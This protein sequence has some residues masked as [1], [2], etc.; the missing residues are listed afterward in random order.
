[1]YHAICIT[2]HDW[3]Q[4]GPNLCVIITQQLLYAILF[5][6]FYLHIAS[7]HDQLW[8]KPHGFSHNNSSATGA[9]LPPFTLQLFITDNNRYDIHPSVAAPNSFPSLNDGYYPHIIPFSRYFHGAPSLNACT[10][11]HSTPHSHIKSG[12]SLC[13]TF[14]PQLSWQVH[15]RNIPQPKS[16]V[17]SYLLSVKQLP[18]CV[19]QNF[20]IS[21]QPRGLAN[22][23]EDTCSFVGPD[24]RSPD[25]VLPILLKFSSTI[26]DRP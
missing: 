26:C 4:C 17:R 24:S 13:L 22:V 5:S 8:H 3:I 15:S 23:R 11:A 20:F 19:R 6:I 21:L 2:S 7:I 10:I 1:M 18:S 25:L 14:P 9:C 16:C 12:C